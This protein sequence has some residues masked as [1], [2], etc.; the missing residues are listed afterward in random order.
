M[1]ILKYRYVSCK[2]PSFRGPVVKGP[3][4]KGPV[5]RP[6]STYEYMLLSTKRRHLALANFLTIHVGLFSRDRKE[7]QRETYFTY[8][9][10]EAFTEVP[11]VEGVLYHAYEVDK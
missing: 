10:L 8:V 1:L 9:L 3:V 7:R 6:P 11:L 4:V 5:V 2:R